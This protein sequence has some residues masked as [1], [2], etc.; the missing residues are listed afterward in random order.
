MADLDLDAVEAVALDRHA[1][2]FDQLVLRDREPADIGV[3]G[4]EL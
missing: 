3:V 4:F 2:A 1:G